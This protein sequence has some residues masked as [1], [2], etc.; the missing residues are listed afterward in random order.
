MGINYYEFSPEDVRPF[1]VAIS[2]SG[3]VYGGHVEKRDYAD[4]TVG[5]AYTR[6]GVV[7]LFAEADRMS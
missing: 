3:H 1:R 7:K 6:E 4:Y 2:D 5:Y